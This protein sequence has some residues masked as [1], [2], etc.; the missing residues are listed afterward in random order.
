MTQQATGML[1][2]DDP[3]SIVNTPVYTATSMTGGRVAGVGTSG[4]RGEG[5]GNVSRNVVRTGDTDT[6]DLTEEQ[7]DKVQ[8]IRDAQDYD[9]N[10]F[11]NTFEY[12]LPEEN[13]QSIYNLTYNQTLSPS[14]AQSF[15][16]VYNSAEFNNDVQRAIQ[17]ARQ[18]GISEDVSSDFEIKQRV[19]N[20]YGIPF[21]GYGSSEEG[22]IEFKDGEFQ[23]RQ[24]WKDTGAETAAMAGAAI[25]ATPIIAPY[26]STAVGTTGLTGTTATAVTKGV[27]NAIVQKA[28]TGDV[29]LKGVAIASLGGAVEGANEVAANAQANVDNLTKITNSNIA[30]E[31]LIA[32]TQLASATQAATEAAATAETL[33]TI[34]N[35]V[36]IGV[37]IEDGNPIKAIDLALSMAESPTLS[38]SVSSGISG[39]VP[40]EYNQA[41]T[42]GIIKAGSTIATG[43]D[44]EQAIQDGVNETLIKTVATEESIKGS[45]NLQGEYADTAAAT[46]SELTTDVLRG[47]NREEILAGGFEAFISNLPESTTK[48]PEFLVKA[49]EWWHTNVED[50]LENYW[51]QIEPQREVVEQAFNDTV[52]V[53]KNVGETV[54]ETADAAIRAVPTTKEQWNELEDTIRENTE[55]PAE[56]FFQGLNDGFEDSDVSIDTPDFNVPDINLSLSGGS[57][58][59]VGDAD[60]V[61]VILEDPE[62]V[63]GFQYEELYNPLMG[64]RTI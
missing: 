62:L 18:S 22:A 64:E 16:Q 47:K 50:P 41:V 12:S 23:F 29:D 58:G 46:I 26:V 6:E 21:K 35:V 15:N 53:V 8:A 57:V 19:M 14:A 52:D 60:I 42:D 34:Q 30:G 55:E 9:L 20:S 43:G 33:N 44:V 7:E 40:D 39:T 31:S 3:L 63:S 51:Q 13:R 54:V 36:D 32:Q 17:E 48:T 37:A 11:M 24:P 4:V 49:E 25:I 5:S 2:N 10:Q 27:T 59:K 38:E 28:I 61:N 1:Y 56:E 45:L